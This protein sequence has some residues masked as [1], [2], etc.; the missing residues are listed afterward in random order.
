MLVGR[1]VATGVGGK[2]FEAGMAVEAALVDVLERQ[3]ASIGGSRCPYPSD[4]IVGR[5]HRLK[6]STLLVLGVV[7]RWRAGD[8]STPTDGAGLED[9][10]R[11]GFRNGLVVLVLDAVPNRL[12]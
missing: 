4:V 2:V 6:A 11:V 10:V 1:L 8:I 9:G 12:E 3:T 5:P 7:G